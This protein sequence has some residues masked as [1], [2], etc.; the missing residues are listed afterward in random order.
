MEADNF[1][2]QCLECEPYGWDKC[3][4]DGWG[5]QSLRN[6]SL[7]HTEVLDPEWVSTAHARKQSSALQADLIK[8]SQE[9]NGSC[10]LGLLC[11]CRSFQ[12]M[13]KRMNSSYVLSSADAKMSK[14][15][16]CLVVFSALTQV[17]KM[18]LKTEQSMSH[19]GHVQGY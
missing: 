11:P 10:T 14:T 5:K 4:T 17:P 15:C 1:C 6:V 7:M 2:R 18:I 13:L 3:C 16:F 9:G 12:R 19:S 8:D